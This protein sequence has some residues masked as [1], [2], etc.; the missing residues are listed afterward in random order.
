MSIQYKVFQ[1]T[2]EADAW[3]EEH[4]SF[5]P[6]DNDNDKIFLQA[7]DYYASHDRKLVAIPE[8]VDKK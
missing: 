2:E 4:K 1:T 7:I 8:T 5:F 3:V 6:S